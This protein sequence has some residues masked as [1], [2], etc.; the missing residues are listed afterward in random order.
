MLAG[1]TPGCVILLLYDS[2]AASSALPGA[3]P[4]A[5]KL[6]DLSAEKFAIYAAEDDGILAYA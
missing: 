4:T 6:C 2:K 3:Q 5:K 1:C